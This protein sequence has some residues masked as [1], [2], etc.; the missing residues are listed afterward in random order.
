MEGDRAAAVRYRERAERVRVIAEATK[1]ANA[2]EIL[3]KIAQAYERMAQQMDQSA[4]IDR[5]L[6][7]RNGP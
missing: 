6:A 3:G 2:R 7:A 4:E 5:R 1:E